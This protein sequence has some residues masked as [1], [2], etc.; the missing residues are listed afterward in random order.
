MIDVIIS[1]NRDVVFSF[2]SSAIQLDNRQNQNYIGFEK[3]R[4]ILP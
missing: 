4:L 2:F 1:L 3:F